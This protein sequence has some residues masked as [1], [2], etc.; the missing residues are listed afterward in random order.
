MVDY[1][2]QMTTAQTNWLGTTAPSSGLDLSG[3]IKTSLDNKGTIT[4]NPYYASDGHDPS[5]TLTDMLTAIDDFGLS[6]GTIDP[7]LDMTNFISIAATLI[8]TYISPD[9]YIT[10]RIAAH[11][12]DLDTELNAKVI[13]RFEAGMR[14]IN[15]VMTSAFAIGRAVIEK[16]RNDKVDKFAA[17]MRFQADD[18]RTGLLQA[19]SAEMVRI[20]LQQKEFERAIASMYIDYGRIDIAANTDY[21]T[22]LKAIAADKARWPYEIYK[23]G[24]NML[25]AMGGGTTS[26]VPMDGNKTARIIGSGL[27]GAAAGAMVGAYI[28]KESGGGI[29]ALVGGIAGLIGGS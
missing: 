5:T 23:Y 11:S 13:P 18:K 2:S 8:S 24:A 29:G 12:A 16:D 6:N 22:E 17:D 25:A 19:L 27:S 7:E 10:A 26:S 9:S 20:L 15:A 3:M 4:G 28:S 21:Q 14:D 1:P